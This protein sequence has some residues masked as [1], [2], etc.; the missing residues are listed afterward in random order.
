MKP[1][2]DAQQSLVEKNLRMA[3]WF[4]NRWLSL[5]PA[6]FADFDDAVQVAALGL[7]SAAS[8]YDESKGKFTTHA[9]W[10]MRSAMVHAT[11]RHKYNS[12]RLNHPIWGAFNRLVYYKAAPLDDFDRSGNGSDAGGNSVGHCADHM[13]PWHDDSPDIAQMDEQEFAE[14]AKERFLAGIRNLRSRGIVR[15]YL[16]TFNMRETA[17]RFGCTYQNVGLILKNAR[18]NFNLLPHAA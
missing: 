17:E 16:T 9:Y 8:N 10:C 4:A 13:E 6:D 2:T 11:F 5:C 3:K 15:H 14:W 1:L 18:K 12:L 7:M